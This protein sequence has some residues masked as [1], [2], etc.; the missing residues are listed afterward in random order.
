MKKLKNFLKRKMAALA[1]ATSNV[2]KNALGQETIDLG[3]DTDTYDYSFLE[4]NR[5]EAL[6]LISVDE[7]KEKYLN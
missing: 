4:N 6:N 2:E 5:K 1:L 3:N 7:F